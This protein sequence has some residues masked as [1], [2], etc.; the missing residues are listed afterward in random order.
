VAGDDVSLSWDQAQINDVYGFRIL[1][2]SAG[3]VSTEIANI[4]SMTYTDF[5]LVSAT[6][7]CYKVIAYDAAGNDSESSE[8]SCATTGGTTP[9]SS[10]VS[11][12]ATTYTVMENATSITITVNRSGNISEAI[13]VDYAV[14]NGTATDGTDFTAAS[15]TLTWAANDNSAKTFDVQIMSDSATEEDETVQIAL[16]SPSANTS[17]GANTIAILTIKDAVTTQ[18]ADLQDTNISQNTS[19]SLPCYNVNSD[20]SVQNAATLTIQPGVMLQFAAG[21]ELRVKSDGALNA[22]GT[23]TAPIIFTG[24]QQ[25]PGYWDGINY[26]SSNNANNELKYVTVEYGGAGGGANLE[27]NSTTRIKLSNTTLRQSAGY[28]V[29]F[30]NGAIIDLFANNTLTTNEGAPVRI[31]ANEVG[32]LDRQ[33]SYTGNVANREYISIFETSNIEDDQTWQALNVPYKL[34]NNSVEAVL[35]IDPGS[36]LIFRQGGNFRIERTGTLIARGTTVNNIIFTGENKP[37]IMAWFAVYFQRN[38]LIELDH[39]SVE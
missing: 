36:T 1:R 27:I 17:L 5:N 34:H 24:A 39:V 3:N 11:F 32:K 13:S 35:M 31:P 8:E 28:G 22:V 9:E 19:L 26:L 4:T 12:S 33:S 20:I 2:G 16:T 25:T 29:F 15:G 23:P 7:Y 38:G 37:G 10:S 14:S 30:G 18:C 21:K 6:D